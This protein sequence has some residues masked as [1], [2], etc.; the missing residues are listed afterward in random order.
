M[1]DG[2][3][4]LRKFRDHVY[5]DDSFVEYYKKHKE[6][7]SL[8]KKT[9]DKIVDEMNKDENSSD[10]VDSVADC[11]INDN[12]PMKLY[13]EYYR[14]DYT[15]WRSRPCS[16]DSVAPLYNW[17][18][19][20]AIEHE[21]DKSWTYELLKLSFI[22]VDVRIVIGY[23]PKENRNQERQTIIR[24]TENFRCA[25]DGEF[26]VVI[27][28]RKLDTNN[29]KDMFNMRVYSIEDN[30]VFELDRDSLEHINLE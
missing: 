21:N 7:T 2:K 26:Y 17:D 25:S 15:I 4:F 9:I 12:I 1:T 28:N 10:D 20:Y 8:I 29:R 18:F 23:V 3:A 13:P 5:K 27:M 30:S 11:K 19:L 22:K 14:I 24:Q 6:Y 16:G